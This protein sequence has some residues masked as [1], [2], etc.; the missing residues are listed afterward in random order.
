M[1][2]NVEYEVEQGARMISKWYDIGGILIVPGVLRKMH[3]SKTKSRKLS[4]T[5]WL[6]SRID[7]KLKK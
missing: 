2:R 4:A 5:L 6:R 3:E 1:E 7:K